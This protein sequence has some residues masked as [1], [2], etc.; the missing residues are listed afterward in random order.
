MTSAAG[1]NSA[2][3]AAPASRRLMVTPPVPR[4]LKGFRKRRRNAEACQRCK[5][6][7]SWSVVR[8]GFRE[9]AM[10]RATI[11]DV[12]SLAGGWIAP[13]SKALNGGQDGRASTR[14]RVLAAAEELSFQPSPL[15]RGLLSGQTRTVG[16]LTSD[17]A[18]RFSIPVLLGAEDAF[19]A[20]ERA[21]PRCDALGAA[22]RVR[23]TLVPKHAR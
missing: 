17:S 14:Q 1:V 6:A 2:R 7:S 9:M 16:L 22:R 23:Y 3:V 4:E 21:V 19:G 12:A 18:G 13:A 8:K 11:S 15:A 20:G 5:V 10:R